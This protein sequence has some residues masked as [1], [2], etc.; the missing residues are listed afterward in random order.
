MSTIFFVFDRC[1]HALA[2][3]RW[4]APRSSPPPPG[5]ARSGSGRKTGRRRADRS[6]PP[7][8]RQATLRQSGRTRFSSSLSRSRTVLAYS[9]RLS[10][11]MGIRP[12][13]FLAASSTSRSCRLTQSTKAAALFGI[14][15]RPSLRRHLAGVDPVDDFLPLLGHLGG[16]EIGAEQ[17]DAKTRLGLLRAMT[18][19]AMRL[20]KGLSDLAKPRLWR[21]IPGPTFSRR[22]GERQRGAEQNQERRTTDCRHLWHGAGS[23]CFR[24]GGP[25]RWRIEADPASTPILQDRF[26]GATG[27]FSR[28]LG[29]SS[30]SWSDV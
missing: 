19:Q 7:C 13:A 1:F 23:L 8:R 2:R 28:G 5:C 18:V 3:S 26:P 9:S 17:I 22:A 29:Q 21:A 24:C 12:P 20:D 10:R 30:G 6:P 11:R 14:G 25:Y 4:P 15:P 16:R 27:L